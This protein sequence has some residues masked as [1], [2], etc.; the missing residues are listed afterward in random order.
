MKKIHQVGGHGYDSNIYLILD[1]SIALIDT[2]TGT[3]FSTIEEKL[4]ALGV[5]P[6]DIDIIVDTH[7]HYDHTGGNKAFALAAGCQVA[8]HELE[9]KVIRG[10][11]PGI[12]MAEA[13]GSKLEPVSSIW[14]I[15]EGDQIELGEMVLEVIETPGHTSGSIC[16]Y[17][18]ERQALFSG[19]TVFYDGIGRMD[20]PTGDRSAMGRSLLRLNGFDVMALF[21]GHGPST[22]NGARECIEAALKMISQG[23]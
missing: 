11:E 1:E 12:A 23:I 9:A 22:E 8:I 7:C 4:A 16:L 6:N 3:N 21:P 18:N 15:C 14:E 2:G 5:R 19:D 20:L 17:D 13:F 10:E